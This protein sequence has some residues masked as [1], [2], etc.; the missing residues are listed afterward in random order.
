MFIIKRQFPFSREPLLYGQ[1]TVFK[2]VAWSRGQSW[3]QKASLA[4]QMMLESGPPTLQ[5]ERSITVRGLVDNN[6]GRNHIIRVG[7][8]VRLQGKRVM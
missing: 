7:V 5:N 3:G 4:E 8:L 6:K 2:E 1:I